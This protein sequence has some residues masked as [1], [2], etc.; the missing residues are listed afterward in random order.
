MTC[1]NV[2]ML[3]C[4]PVHSLCTLA[5][6]LEREECWCIV[7]LIDLSMPIAWFDGL[8]YPVSKY[9]ECLGKAPIIQLYEDVI[10]HIGMI[11]HIPKNASSAWKTATCCNYKDL[12]MT[13]AWGIFKYGDRVVVIYWYIL[14]WRNSN[15]LRNRTDLGKNSEIHRVVEMIIIS[16]KIITWLSCWMFWVELWDEGLW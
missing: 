2:Q 8:K 1:W 14:N 3:K 15:C 9:L 5:N 4:L 7:I 6:Y 13:W 16:A 10:L 12:S 11:L